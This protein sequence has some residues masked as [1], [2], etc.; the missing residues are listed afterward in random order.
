MNQR[1]CM[2]TH[3]TAD[4]TVVWYRSMYY[5]E[6]LLPNEFLVFSTYYFYSD[7]KICLYSSRSVENN[8]L[9]HYWRNGWLLNQCEENNLTV[10]RH[11][12]I[13]AKLCFQ[14]SSVSARL[15]E[16]LQDIHKDNSI[17][18]FMRIVCC[19]LGKG[20]KIFIFVDFCI[21]IHYFRK[22]DYR[23]G[24]WKGMGIC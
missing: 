17:Y 11:A 9:C 7:N 16:E 4:M 18:K 3:P 20:Y 6:N 21:F 10:E 13:L 12:P 24:W 19:E 5:F 2:E 1:R 14:W 15:E 8:I 22:Y 23:I